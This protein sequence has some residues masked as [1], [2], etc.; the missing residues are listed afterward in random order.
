MLFLS[1][2]S[3]SW[4]AQLP[5]PAPAS[6]VQ[7]MEAAGVGR[8]LSDEADFDCRWSLTIAHQPDVQQTS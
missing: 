8:L 5:S 3:A 1:G 7:L 6:L 4:M 2:Q